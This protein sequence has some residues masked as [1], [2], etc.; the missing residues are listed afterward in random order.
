M[1]GIILKLKIGSLN[2]SFCTENTFR[3][4]NH[5]MLLKL[6]QCTAYKIVL[7][8]S[9]L[10]LVLYSLHLVHSHKRVITEQLRNSCDGHVQLCWL[11]D[12]IQVTRGITL[13]D[14]IFDLTPLQQ[15]RTRAFLD[16]PTFHNPFQKWTQR[17]AS[18]EAKAILRFAKD[19]ALLNGINYKVPAETNKT[20]IFLRG[21]D[22]NPH[23]YFWYKYSAYI[24]EKNVYIL[25][26]E[27]MK[28]GKHT[29]INFIYGTVRAKKTVATCSHI[30]NFHNYTTNRYKFICPLV[31]SK[32]TITLRVN[33]LSI[34]AVNFICKSNNSWHLRTITEESVYRD[35]AKSIVEIN[36]AGTV[37]T[38]CNSSTG[39]EL[40]FWLDIDRMYHWA[41][42][43]CYFPFKFSVSQYQCLHTKNIFLIGDS[44]MSQRFHAIR[45]AYTMVQLRILLARHS[46]N[47]LC[48]LLD[49][50]K[51]IHNGSMSAD[52]LVVNA[53]NH[54]LRFL[55]IE[56]YLGTMIDILNIFRL[57][58]RFTPPP[59]IIWI[60]TLPSKFDGFH[61][62]MMTNQAVE[63]CNDW[64][65]HNMRPLGIYV[66]RAFTIAL[67]MTSHST[68]GTHYTALFG[69]NTKVQNKTNVEGAIIS[70]VGLAICPTKK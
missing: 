54:D 65:N 60:E 52:I 32:F 56:M 36:L 63:A 70:I 64:I 68:D 11:R 42:K 45:K 4:L 57:L 17:I 39:H 62:K 55:N 12:I 5:N 26:T 31:E 1:L 47:V 43:T 61:G 21:C 50:Y 2:L 24:L 51:G 18:L 48:I 34:S 8:I 38:E 19:E 40:G 41:T 10:L 28:K 37:R 30:A 46:I 58:L 44:H 33:Y 29:V 22:Y 27:S 66:I 23:E 7:I 15:F 16:Y 6:E 20:D 59:K 35:A 53:G 14:D 25:I 13:S 49:L 69:K 3:V 67:S 9:P